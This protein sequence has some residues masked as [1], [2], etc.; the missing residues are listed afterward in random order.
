MTRYIVTRYIRLPRLDVKTTLDRGTAHLG[1]PAFQAA[2]NGRPAAFGTADV[3]VWVRKGLETNV[4]VSVGTLLAP[5]GGTTP[6]GRIAR[7]ARSRCPSCPVQSGAMTSI[8]PVG[9]RRRHRPDRR[10]AASGGGL[11]ARDAARRSPSCSTSCATR[12]SRF[13]TLWMRI[14]ERSSRTA[15]RA[16]GR[17]RGH[18]PPPDDAKVTTSRPGSVTR[19]NYEIWISDGEIVRTYGAAHKLGTQRPVRRNRAPRPGRPRLPG[20]S[21]L[22]AAHGACRWRP[23]RR[24]FVHPG[25]LLPEH[26]LTGDC[27]DHG[28]RQVAGREAIV[29]ECD[30]PRAIEVVADRP[31]FRISL[32]GRSRG[33]G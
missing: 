9:P 6:S 23:C 32:C 15:R 12:S 13:A 30:H 20:T 7:A 17:S 10:P 21:G 3:P 22:R 2:T 27:T 11:A 8:T 33:S 14:V 24:H 16:S 5:S 31:D 25:G 28:P 26:A 4:W 18:A 19:A 1:P 29:L